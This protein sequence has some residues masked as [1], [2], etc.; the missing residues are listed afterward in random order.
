MCNV[1]LSNVMTDITNQVLHRIFPKVCLFYPNS[2]IFL[3]EIFVLKKILDRLFQAHSHLKCTTAAE[4]RRHLSNMNVIASGQ[5]VSYVSV[6][7]D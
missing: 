1:L 7:A 6:N 3:F 5:Q 4:P 2:L